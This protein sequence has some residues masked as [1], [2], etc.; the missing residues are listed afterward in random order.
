MAFEFRTIL[1]PDPPDKILK[2]TKSRKAKKLSTTRRSASIRKATIN[3]RHFE[4]PA[5][6]TA[7]QFDRFLSIDI[8]GSSI[9]DNSY[10]QPA[11]FAT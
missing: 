6:G 8:V 5:F 2:E 7:D 9:K 11:F 4:K 3:G 1:F 10:T